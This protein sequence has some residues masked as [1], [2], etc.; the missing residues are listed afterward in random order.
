MRGTL[1]RGVVIL[2]SMCACAKSPVQDPA[3]SVTIEIADAAKTSCVKLSATGDPGQEVLSAG[4]VRKS[5]VRAALFPSDQLKGQIK[6]LARGYV[7]NGCQ[8]PLTLNE[9]SAVVTET[10]VKGETRQVT[11]RIEPP[12][13]DMDADQDGYRSSGIGGADC[14]DTSADRRPD[15]LELC[16]N[17]RDDDCDRLAD[18]AD[19]GCSGIPCTDSNLCTTNETCQATRLCGGGQAMT[20]TPPAGSCLV[21]GTCGSATGTC[22]FVARDAGLTCNDLDPCTLTDVCRTDGGC[23]GTQKV[24]GTSPG[25]CFLASGS[26]VPGDGG[27]TYPVNLGGSCSDGVACTAA[28]TCL[29]DG[30]CS[31]TAFTCLAP[32]GECYVDA[33]TCLADAGCAYAVDTAR[34]FFLCDGGACRASGSCG[35]VAFPFA[36]SNF[37]PAAI[38][39]TEI[40]RDVVLNCAA[41]FDSTAGAATPFVNWC[42]QQQPAV[43]VFVQDGGSDVVVLPMFRFNL[44]DAGSLRVRGNRPVILAV[45]DSAIVGGSLL[46]TATLEDAGPGGSLPTCLGTG[47]A[48]T[49]DGGR[50]GGGGGGGFATAGG[51]G[52]GANSATT[53][54]GGAGAAFGDPS[55]VPLLGGCSGGRGFGTVAQAGAG[56]GGGGAIQLSVAGRWS[57]SESFRRPAAVAVKRR[58]GPPAAVVVGAAVASLSKRPRCP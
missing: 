16:A 50:G 20:C 38:L 33:G 32:P 41:D 46:A 47:D 21:G 29:E 14:D 6:L 43:K 53:A 58:P 12:T 7:G 11:L 40:A 10:F 45:Y 25:Q 37:D 26:C 9:E 17:G 19:P 36:P 56:G 52:G 23:S 48:G 2:V 18:C 22:S 42:S 51:V 5:L 27:C 39:P 28:D 54:A 13:V 44:P 1:F 57:W 8:E 4:V 35:A 34:L 31:G 49:V 15:A 55:L 3:I 24:C 30:G